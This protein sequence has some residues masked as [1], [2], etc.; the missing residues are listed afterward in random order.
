M[1]DASHIA[2]RGLIGD[3]LVVASHGLVGTGVEPETGMTVFDEQ[4]GVRQGRIRPT[5]TPTT[6]GDWAYV[7]GSDVE[8]YGGDLEPGDYAQI[9]Q[10][11]DLTEAHVFRADMRLRV[12][13]STPG[14]RRWRVSILVDG[15]VKASAA[16]RAGQTRLVSDLA[17]DVSRLTGVH[18]V[19]IRV[20]LEAVS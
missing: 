3:G 8:G 12:P 9:S 19:A 18:Q 6:S 7:L 1:L 2:T 16:G 11:V 10:A 14:N 13:T 20:A 5:T 15:V 4:L 17:A